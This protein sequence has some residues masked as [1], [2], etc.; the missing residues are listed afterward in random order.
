MAVLGADLIYPIYLAP[1]SAFG[2][3]GFVPITVDYSNVR[4]KASALA[5]YGMPGPAANSY[6]PYVQWVA[7]V[8]ATQMEILFLA[9]ACVGLAVTIGLS[10]PTIFGDIQILPRHGAATDY[11]NMF[12]ASYRPDSVE[13]R[14]AM[15]AFASYGPP[16]WP[17]LPTKIISS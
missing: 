16:G 1:S 2:T 3:S 12:F 6:A 13:D 4:N 17:W 11:M 5:E 15:A 14:A 8:P 9:A 10:N 7:S